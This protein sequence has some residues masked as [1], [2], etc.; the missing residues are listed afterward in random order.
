[1]ATWVILNKSVLAERLAAGDSQ[2]EAEKAA[3]VY[4]YNHD[5]TIEMKDFPFATHDHI[6]QVPVN[7]DGSIEGSAVR[8]FDKID[9][10]RQFTGTEQELI[11]EFNATFESNPMLT[12]DQKRKIRTGLEDYKA[13]PVVRSD[14]PKV[15]VMLGLYV[16]LGILAPHRPQEILNG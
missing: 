4:R 7:V 8:A 3:E 12:E 5:A 6:E 2:A 14:D 9:W 15:P 10:R 16:A 11:D 1:M 13:A